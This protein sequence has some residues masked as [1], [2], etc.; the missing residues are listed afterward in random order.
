MVIVTA[1]AIAGAV[2]LRI[3]GWNDS[4]TWV[5][6]VVMLV[7]LVLSYLQSRTNLRKNLDGLITKG[8]HLQAIV[9]GVPDNSLKSYD[10]ESDQTIE[11]I[12]SR[13]D[14]WDTSIMK[15]LKDTK[16][17]GQWVSNAGLTKPEDE[18]KVKGLDWYLVVWRNY[19]TLRLKR[20]EDIRNGL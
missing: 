8:E 13:L 20:L 7:I 17:D 12:S 9:N 3:I 2:I 18:S 10:T 16:Y 11:R 15:V 1:C 5:V 6:A 14:E 19:M 4:W